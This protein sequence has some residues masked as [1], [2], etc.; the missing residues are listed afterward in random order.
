MF[1]A[2]SRYSDIEDAVLLTPDGRE[3][4]Y[5][6]RRFL[7]QGEKLT[8]LIEM[9]VRDG[10]IV[11]DLNGLGSVPWEKVPPTPPGGRRGGSAAP[12]KRQ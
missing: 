10:V 7:P 3:V 8:L 9:T 2:S 11:H 12:P 6:R 5:K 4:S 1:D